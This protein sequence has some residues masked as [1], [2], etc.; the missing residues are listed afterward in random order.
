MEIRKFKHK[1]AKLASAL[2]EECFRSLDLGGHTEE[3]KRL[4]IESNRPENL[5]KRAQSVRYFVACEAN[6]IIGICGYDRYKV[7]TLFV[8]IDHQN[9]GIGKALLNKVL[10]EAIKDGLLTIDTWA[11]LY[12]ERFYRVFGFKRTGEIHL[13]NGR[14][15]IVLIEMKKNLSQIK[16]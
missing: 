16:T 7:Q 15:E 4:Q 6:R 5:I 9:R 3:G 8:D 13:P 12:S 10:S 1:D 14:S 11:T 2:I